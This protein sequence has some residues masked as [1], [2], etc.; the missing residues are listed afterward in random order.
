MILVALALATD[1]PTRPAPMPAAAGDCAEAE[2]LPP[3]RSLSCSAVAMPPAELADLLAVEAWASATADVC[4]VRL[5][6]ADAR[7]DVCGERAA[8]W[9]RVAEGPRPE[10]P[11]AAWLGIG[12]GLGAGAVLAGAWAVQIVSD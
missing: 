7:L 11:P 10:L 4:R 9:Q 8:Y 1:L 6:D 3:G 2:P 5:A 12:A